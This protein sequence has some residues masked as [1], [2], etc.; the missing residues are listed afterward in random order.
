M[1]TIS[2]L[3][4]V[5]WEQ[6]YQPSSPGSI[7]PPSWV[8]K[9]LSLAAE[10][11]PPAGITL[12]LATDGYDLFA[13]RNGTTVQWA[14]VQATAESRGAPQQWD[15]STSSPWLQYTDEQGRE[16]RSGGGAQ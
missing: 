13:D 8:D 1:A 2:A 11:V 16:H 9:V 10:P 7:A 14:D 15:A 3:F 4:L 6:V 12:G 5:S